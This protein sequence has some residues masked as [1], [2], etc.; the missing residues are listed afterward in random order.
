MQRPSQPAAEVAQALPKLR[1]NGW[2]VAKA[3][4]SAIVLLVLFWKFRNDLSSLNHADPRSLGLAV[5]LLLLQPPI[6][7]L[8]WYLL[9]R[10]YGG[11]PRLL[12][13]TEITWVAVFANQFLPS[14]VGADAVR[15]YAAFRSGDTLAVV[16]ASVFMDRVMALLALA[17][18]MVVLALP[19][20]S[21][22]GLATIAVLGV[23]CV[24]CIPMAIAAFALTRSTDWASRWPWLQR[25]LA[26]SNYILNIISHPIRGMAAL[27]LS[28]VVHL[29]SLAAFVVI[30]YGMGMTV[31][32][33]ALLAVGVL[34]AFV[35][36]VPI[37]ISGWGVRE[38]SAI[39][40]FGLVGVAQG[41]AL[42]SSVLLGLA[43][44][45]ATLPGAAMAPFL[46]AK[47]PAPAD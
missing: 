47:K 4:L 7:A 10:V 41:P 26:I 6:I 35:Q 31:G 36:V 22:I 44:A 5:A 46:R 29:L 30:A 11:K 37:S 2:F 12:L 1:I 17:I 27:G 13:L 14:A 33:A 32:L 42:V 20:V 25:V 9:Y 19:L 3:A 24:A 34:L 43:Y 8:R 15:I 40:L 39:A 28:L 38:V 21:S 45:A 18:L 23:A 16:A